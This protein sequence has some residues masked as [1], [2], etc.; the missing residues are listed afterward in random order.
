M[1]KPFILNKDKI[2]VKLL[3]MKNNV[4]I[5]LDLYYY[6]EKYISLCVKWNCCLF[7]MDTNGTFE[8]HLIYFN[9]KEV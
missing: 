3:S 4:R 2:T 6:K 7:G 8:Q 9:R 5:Y 1:L